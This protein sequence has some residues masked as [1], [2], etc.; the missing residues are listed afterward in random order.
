[1]NAHSEWTEPQHV[2]GGGGLEG[3]VNGTFPLSSL[4]GSEARWQMEF[5]QSETRANGHEKLVEINY[6]ET[7]RRESL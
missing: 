1:M 4:G 6:G 3:T 7:G 2:H 5:W